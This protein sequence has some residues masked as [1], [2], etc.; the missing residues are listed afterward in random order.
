[1]SNTIV[2][3][4]SGTNTSAPSSLTYGEI[5]INYSDGKLFYKDS[6]DTIVAVKLIKNITGTSGEVTVTET[7]GTFNISL[8]NSVYVSNLFVN[9]VEIDTA[10]ASTHYALIFDGVKFSPAPAPTGPTGPTGPDRLQVSDTAP[11]SPNEGDLW[12]N[13]NQGRLFSYFDSAWIEISGAIGPTGATG[14]DRLQVSDTAPSGVGDGDLWF[15]SSNARLFSYYDSTWVEISGAIGPTGPTGPL[16]PT[17]STGPTGPTGPDR[18]QVASTAPSS[19]NSGDLWFDSSEA[20]LYS[21]YDGFWVEI[22]GEVGPTGPTGPTGEIGP[23]GPTGA[24]G[25]AGALNDLSD[26]TISNVANGQLLQ[27]NGTEWVNA[28]SVSQEPMGHEDATQSTISFNESTRVFTISPVSS[29]FNVWV[30]GVKYTKT[31]SQTV[32]IPNTSGLYYIYFDSSGSLQY[33]TT[34]F[35]WDDDAPTAYIYWNATNSKAYFFADERHGVALDWQTHEYLHRTR[36]AAIAQGFGANNFVLDGDGTSDTHAKIDIADGTFFDED[37]EVHIT[38]SSTPVSNTWQQRLQNGAYIPVF[39]RSDSSW[40]KDI[41]TQFPMKQGISRVQ[42]NLNSSGVWSTVDLEA[43]K[44][45]I[46]WVTAT[47]NL[48]EPVLSILGQNSYNTIGEA[49][50]RVWEDLD[51]SDLP[52]F[53]LRPLYKIIYQTNTGYTNT[54]HARIVSV[55]DLRT[56]HPSGG[57]ATLP[58]S[59]H[60]SM[61]GLSDDDHPQYLL[62]DGSRSISGSLIPDANEVY[63]LGSSSYRFRDLYLSGASINLGGLEITSDGLSLSMPPIAAVSGDFTVNTNTLHVDSANSRVGIGTTS[64]SYDL[65]VAGNAYVSDYIDTGNSVLES[66]TVNI[67][68]N[69]QTLA[70]SFVMTSYPSVE[71]FIQ[72]K[73]GSKVR[74]SKVHVIT[75]GSSVDKTE[76]GV[77]ELNGSISGVSVDVSTSGI[78]ALLYVT[79]TDGAS[80]SAKVTINKTA[81]KV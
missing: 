80:T 10:G 16:G 14:P 6:S 75:D 32:T 81:I 45:G 53:E 56:I 29:Q 31:T 64:P 13:S 35:D 36:G 11:S 65:H 23:T 27:Y 57:V 24:S 30:K 54:P 22:S 9:N 74:C 63:D 1:M 70:D 37:L 5:A 21:Y 20:K 8:P 61:T 42:Y 58:V 47:N 4:R 72:I 50:A 60:G 7:S 77:L 52:I 19:P 28:V 73:Q 38:H 71:Y 18:L 79:V 49:E 34:Y 68:S 78:N 12:F 44:F 40:V 17:G 76:Y 33:K 2:L 66:L 48:N 59:D 26:V 62:A 39:Y 25:V 3:K 46:S 67:N 51:L 41:A 15:N 43:N 55:I 69:T